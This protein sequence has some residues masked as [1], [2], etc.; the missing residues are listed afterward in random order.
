MPNFSLIRFCTCK[1]SI[2]GKLKSFPPY[3]SP[4][5]DLT[6]PCATKG[7]PGNMRLA[8]VCGKAFFQTG[9]L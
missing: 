4:R 6:K 7:D 2:K 8:P 1:Y 5:P 9:K 3:K